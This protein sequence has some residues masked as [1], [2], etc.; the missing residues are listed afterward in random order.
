MAEAQ[1]S[2]NLEKVGKNLIR[3]K[4]ELK[5]TWCLAAA[6]GVVFLLGIVDIW[7][8]LGRVDRFIVWVLLLAVIGFG[9][10]PV[11]N[12]LRKRYSSE[13]VAAMIEAELRVKDVQ[14]IVFPHPTVGEVVRDAMFEFN[15]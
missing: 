4:A 11:L 10:R 6:L 14:E 2:R 12:A 13:G 7:L 9:L 8:Q 15:N 3:W 5:L 1:A